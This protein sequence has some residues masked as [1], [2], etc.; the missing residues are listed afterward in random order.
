MIYYF[1]GTGNSQYIA[2][3]L[4]K[5]LNED[6][7][8]INTLI[9]NNNHSLQNIQ[10]TLVFVVLRYEESGVI[11]VVTLGE[12][13]DK[14]S[15]VVSDNLLL[16]YCIE[17]VG[18]ELLSKAYERVNQ[19]VYEE[20]KM[21]LANYQ[22]LQTEDIKKGLDAVKT[23]SVTWKKGMLRPAKSVVLRADYV[24]DRGK[25]GCEHCSQCGNVNCVFR[26]QTINPNNLSKRSNTNA[27]GKNVYSYGINQIF[28]NNRKN[29]E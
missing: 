15:D 25:S 1:T 8:S 23:T 16:S 7:M 4:H 14:L 28:G 10:G 11:C 3:E 18:M 21:W 29:E 19:Y 6:Y 13:F 17:C 9:R 26:K 5:Q 20:R 12:R 2:R 27:V 22:F 24:E